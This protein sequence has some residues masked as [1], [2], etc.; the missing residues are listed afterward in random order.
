[1]GNDECL[2]EV[3]LKQH[4]RISPPPFTL[5]QVLPQILDLPGQRNSVA[6]RNAHPT[7]GASQNPRDLTAGVTDEEHRAAGCK[8]SVKLARHNKGFER[9]LE[10]DEV[11]VGN[12]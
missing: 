4:S 8:Y 7:V 12:R 9:R 11:H 10:R 2:V 1:M 5:L 6:D 3:A